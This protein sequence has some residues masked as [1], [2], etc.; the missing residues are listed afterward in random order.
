MKNYRLSQRSLDR[1]EGCDPKIL[2]IVNLAITYTAIDFGIAHNG[3]FRS[4]EK[5]NKIFKDGASTKDGHEK[6]SKHQDGIAFDYLCYDNNGVTWNKHH[7]FMVYGA[8]H[9][10]AEHLG[11]AI[12]WGGNWDGDSDFNDQN[13]NDYGHV[14]LC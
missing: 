13:F 7:Y 2:K 12:R 6:R 14:E 8:I 5:Q 11:I 3:G 1:L 9:A 4:A 10:A